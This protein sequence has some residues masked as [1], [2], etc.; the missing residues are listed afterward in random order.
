MTPRFE[1][2]VFQKI[3]DDCGLYIDEN[4]HTISEKEIEF[5]AEQIVKYAISALK[6]G[7][8]WGPNEDLMDTFF[9]K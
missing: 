7:G 6:A 5:F 3:A 8:W 1:N 2:E 9:P 4:N